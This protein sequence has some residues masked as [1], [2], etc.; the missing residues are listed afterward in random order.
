M[1]V[2][3]SSNGP[4][5][6]TLAE[7]IDRLGKVIDALEVGLNEAVAGAVQAA[8]A[9]A[10]RLGVQT[11]LTE[12]LTD[13][14]LAAALAARGDFDEAVRTGQRALDKATAAGDVTSANN[15]RDHLLLY[16]ER[17]PVLGSSP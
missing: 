13:P 16:Q 9:Q 15:I 1:S 11:A 14:T 6:T 7:Q 3:M 4:S 10:V 8:V 17:K 12:A 5:R 2:K